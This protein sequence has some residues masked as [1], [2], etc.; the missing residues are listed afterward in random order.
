MEVKPPQDFSTGIG[1]G[2]RRESGFSA[3]ERELKA[4]QASNLGRLARKVEAALEALRSAPDDPAVRSQLVDDAAHAV[5]LYF[6]QREVSGITSHEQAIQIYGIPKEVLA[7]V[8]ASAGT[9]RSGE[10]R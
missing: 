10:P 7:R 2:T 4:E 1:T 9:P 5:W 6:V 8:G 3:L